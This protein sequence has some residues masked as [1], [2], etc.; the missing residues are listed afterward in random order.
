LNK[1]S[2]QIDLS[3]KDRLLPEGDLCQMDFVGGDDRR[4]EGNSL[5]DAAIADH[6][7]QRHERNDVVGTLRRCLP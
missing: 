3:P 1:P 2:R 6:V 4:L 7:V 5:S